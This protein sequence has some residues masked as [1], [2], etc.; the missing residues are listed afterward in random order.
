MLIFCSFIP[1]Y[2][3]I[4]FGCSFNMF[5]TF[6]VTSFF[7]TDIIIASFPFPLELLANKIVFF[8]LILNPDF[9]G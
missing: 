3:V 4:N 6:Q 9:V 1:D 2:C 5:T 8:F 7:V